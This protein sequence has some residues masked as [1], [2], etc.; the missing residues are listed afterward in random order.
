[1]VGLPAAVS[2]YATWHCPEARVHE[3]TVNEPD[4]E[5]VL[6]VTVP[7]GLNPPVRVAVHVVD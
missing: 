2:V 5:L 3:A 6:K 4:E 7:D 1:M